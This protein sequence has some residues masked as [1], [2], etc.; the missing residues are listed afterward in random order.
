MKASRWGVADGA[1]AGGGGGSS[2][3]RAIRLDFL[4]SVGL[5]AGAGVAGA[6]GG[7]GVAP[8]GCDGGTPKRS[9]GVAGRGRGACIGEAG[10][11]TSLIIRST[12]FLDPPTR[13]IGSVANGVLGRD[14]GS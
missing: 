13:G 12:L 1:G 6:G 10:E 11:W 3:N 5:G 4:C 14:P 7:A 9:S 8:A 2:F